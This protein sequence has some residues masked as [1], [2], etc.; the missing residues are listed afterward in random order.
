MIYSNCLIE[1]YNYNYSASWT[2]A[3]WAQKIYDT[4]AALYGPQYVYNH[5]F[6]G[7]NEFCIA[8]IFAALSWAG[9]A[10]VN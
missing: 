3:H 7:R 4:G 1:G 8:T 5:Y 6:P 10:A 9:L 2:H